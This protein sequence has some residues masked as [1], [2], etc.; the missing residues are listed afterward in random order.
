MTTSK[1]FTKDALVEGKLDFHGIVL[2]AVVI[3]MRK[4]CG[5][6]VKDQNRR[7]AIATTKGKCIRNFLQ[8]IT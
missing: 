8:T 7:E 3:S 2:N 4:K 1:P 6:G 5:G